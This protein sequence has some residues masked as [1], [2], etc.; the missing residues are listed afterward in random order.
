MRAQFAAFGPQG[1]PVL[2]QILAAVKVGLMQ[3][4]HTVFLCSLGFL[5]VGFFVV[6]FLPEIELQPVQP[7][8]KE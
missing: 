1:Q 8:T 7:D 3:S 4:L 2:E 6:F 5:L